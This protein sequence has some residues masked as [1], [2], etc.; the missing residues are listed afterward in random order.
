MSDEGANLN[1]ADASSSE[2]KRRSWSDLRPRLIS[3]FILLAITILV[4][5]AGGIWFAIFVALGFAGVM[6]EWEKMISRK[7]LVLS[8]MILVGVLALIPIATVFFGHLGAL[9]FVVIGL[10]IVLLSSNPHKLWRAG[11][12]LFFTAVML[13]LINIRGGS[14]LGFAACFFL[15]PRSG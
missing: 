1:N 7:P 8:G 5:W 9:V 4:V 12:F 11:G 6:I 14:Y 15:A 3:A 13:S 2:N 10:A